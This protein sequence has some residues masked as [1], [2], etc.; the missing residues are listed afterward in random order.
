V[1]CV[2]CG[3]NA[4]FDSL[5]QTK[6]CVINIPTREWA[7]QVV[8]IGNCSGRAVDKFTQFGFAPVAAKQVQ[9]P[10]RGESYASLERRVVDMRR[11]G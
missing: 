6:E 9:A 4:H 1:G 5:K 11:V 7:K 3:C 2:I 10:L 8:G